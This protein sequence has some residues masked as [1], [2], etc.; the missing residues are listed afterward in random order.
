MSSLQKQ[1]SDGF[2][3]KKKKDNIQLIDSDVIVLSQVLPSVGVDILQNICFKDIL[4]S[5]YKNIEVAGRT[6]YKSEDKITAGSAKKFYDMLRGRGHNAMIEHGILT[7]A[8]FSHYQYK[9]ELNLFYNLLRISGLGRFIN[10]TKTFIEDKN[11]PYYMWYRI[12]IS[13]NL[14]AFKDFEHYLNTIGSEDVKLVIS[15]DNIEFTIFM[16]KVLNLKLSII[17]YVDI[18]SGLTDKEKDKHRYITMR[19]ICDRGVSHE[20]V[21]HRLFSFA[22]ESTRYVRY[23]KNEDAI[24]IIKPAGY[25]EWPAEQRGVFLSSCVECFNNYKYLLSYGQTPQQARAVL[26]NAIKTEVVVTGNQQEW[27]HFF[28]LRCAPEAHPDMQIVANKAKEL[29]YNF[30]NLADGGNSIIY[31][32]TADSDEEEETES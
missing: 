5:L 7:F 17:P 2:D 1:F 26:I 9:D 14:R 16:N 19:F 6:C 8:T 32:V 12:I 23:G 27:K 13:G 28:N 18:L 11:H 30:F 31:E 24:K 22:Q 21:R 4:D 15:D 25:D 29:Y 3:N 20:L 10:V